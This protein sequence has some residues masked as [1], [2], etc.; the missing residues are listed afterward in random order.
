MKACL[1]SNQCTVPENTRLLQDISNMFDEEFMF[2][3]DTLFNLSSDGPNVTKTIQ[4]RMN[5]ALKEK[6]GPLIAF[7]PCNLHVVHNSFWEGLNL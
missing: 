1:P 6:M 7:I 3:A 5:E 2:P 4:K